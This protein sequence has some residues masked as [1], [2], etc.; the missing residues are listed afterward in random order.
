MPQELPESLLH[1]PPKGEAPADPK[2][3]M[4]ENATPL[5]MVAPVG[6]DTVF[7]PADK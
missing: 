4:V 6:D 5:K 7:P 2:D 1:S 3:L